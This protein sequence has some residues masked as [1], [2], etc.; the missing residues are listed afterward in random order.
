[1]NAAC[2]WAKRGMKSASEFF[3]FFSFCFF[4]FLLS[5]SAVVACG[6]GQGKENGLALLTC[7]GP[8]F[9]YFGRY[10][11]VVQQHWLHCV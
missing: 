5:L 10:W 6:K 8:T 4:F 3:L 7:S 2:R 1:M 9:G 11:S